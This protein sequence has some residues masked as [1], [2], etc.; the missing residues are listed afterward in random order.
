MIKRLFT[1][2]VGCICLV[3]GAQNA[4]LEDLSVR[5]SKEQNREYSYTDKQSGYW[6]GRTHQDVPADYYSGWNIAKR[7]VLRDFAIYIVGWQ[8]K[9]AENAV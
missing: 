9:R 1:V 4:G 7:R 3:S 6:Y 8:F 2:T 5:V